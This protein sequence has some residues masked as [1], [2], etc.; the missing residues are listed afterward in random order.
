[1][2]TLEVDG[3]TLTQSLAIIEYLN[4]TRG[5][6]LPED[7]AGRARVRALSYAV[8]METHP[9]CN[10]SVA[11]YAVDASGGAISTEAWMAHFITKGLGALEVMLSAP[12]TGRFCHGDSVTMADLCL[13]PQVYNAR[14]WGVDMTAMPVI[15]RIDADLAT[16]PAIATAHPD[17]WAKS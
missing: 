3:L 15:S 13:V 5:G 9:I 4:D 11:A 17:M 12:G 7:A 14:R 16:L 1:M 8:A 6:L 2:P 10:S